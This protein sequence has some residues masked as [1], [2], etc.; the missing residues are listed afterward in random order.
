MTSHPPPRPQ[1]PHLVLQSQQVVPMNLSFLSSFS[2]RWRVLYLQGIREG[3]QIALRIG[4]G[5]EPW[6]QPWSQNLA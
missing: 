2:T 5:V 4:L 6:L 1:A 3:H